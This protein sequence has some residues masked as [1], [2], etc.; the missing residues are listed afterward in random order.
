MYSLMICDDDA[1]TRRELRGHILRFEKETGVRFSVEETASG[2]E[3]LKSFPL[4][5]DILLL[6]IKMK[7]TSGMNAARE[8]RQRGSDV[9]IIF[10]TSM[11]Q[12][13]IEGYEVHAFG[14]LRKPISY[15]YFR[16]TLSDAMR[17]LA[18]NASVRV[19]L[20]NGVT[21]DFVESS[22]IAYIEIANHSLT[23]TWENGQRSVYKMTLA[24][25]EEQLTQAGFVR[26]HRSYLVNIRQIRRIGLTDITMLDGVRI[27]LSKYRKKEFL[28]AVAQF[29]EMR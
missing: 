3:L 9:L 29:K 7:A 26:C 25:L 19:E 11:T 24:E 4:D 17:H 18:R 27:P 28:E 2:E 5:T 15:D 21:S 20:R 6:D 23:I 8:I 13:A 10:I 22:K 16:W 1:A 12:Y 14:F